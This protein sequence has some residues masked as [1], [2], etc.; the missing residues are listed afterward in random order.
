MNLSYFKIDTNLLVLFSAY[1]WKLTILYRGPA[2]FTTMPVNGETFFGSKNLLACT[3][4]VDREK[5]TSP[6]GRI[7]KTNCPPRLLVAHD[8]RVAPETGV[9]G[10]VV[11]RTLRTSGAS[12]ALGV[13]HCKSRYEGYHL[14]RRQIGP[15]K[16]TIRQQ[17]VRVRVVSIFA[18]RWRRLWRPFFF[19]FRIADDGVRSTRFL[20]RHGR[21]HPQVSTYLIKYIC[22]I[23]K[24]NKS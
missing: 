9:R 20:L 19:L 8:E 18:S 3:Q 15:R 2:M 12:V 21:R 13:R 5:F 4:I 11:A 7:E 16:F 10:P 1:Y 24:I 22:T 6:I 14:R 23:S 17:L